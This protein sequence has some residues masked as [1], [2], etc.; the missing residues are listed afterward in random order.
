MLECFLVFFN[1]KTKM[2]KGLTKLQYKKSWFTSLFGML[3]KVITD[4]DSNQ[5]VLVFKMALS[6]KTID[7]YKDKTKAEKLLECEKPS[8]MGWTWEVF[9]PGEQRKKL[10]SITH[11]PLKT[12]MKMGAESWEI[13]GPDDQTFLTLD[14]EGDSA[15]KRVLDSMI[16]VYNPKHQ[17]VIKGADGTTVAVFTSK[18]GLFG[19][20]YDF[21]LEGGTD[22]Q[23]NLAVALFAAMTLLLKK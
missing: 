7:I 11:H 20:Q 8:V 23:K 15:A 1:P 16:S 13:K 21:V 4:P 10:G 22:E 12:M 19:G 17:Y 6:A 14:T 18:H 2:I 5:P 3:T 9:D